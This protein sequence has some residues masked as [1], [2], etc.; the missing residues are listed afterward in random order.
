MIMIKERMHGYVLLLLIARRMD[1][2]FS[3]WPTCVKNLS[4]MRVL[5]W[6][7]LIYWPEAVNYE[8]CS[9]LHLC[10]TKSVSKLDGLIL[11]HAQ[12]RPCNEEKP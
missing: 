1:I 10:E 12:V 2:Y 8:R 6:E 9:Q 3:P 11:K 4:T 5:Q 7:T